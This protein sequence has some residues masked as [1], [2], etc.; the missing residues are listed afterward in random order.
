MHSPLLAAILL[1]SA[2]PQGQGTPTPPPTV[3]ETTV[4]PQARVADYRLPLLREGSAIARVTGDLTQDPDEKVWLFRPLEP[5]AGTIRR[6]FVL[7]PSPVLEDMLR[8]ERIAGAPVQFEMSGRVFIYHGRNFLL[9]DFA[10]VIMRFDAAT[11]ERPAASEA[12]QPAP[13][14]DDRFVPAEGDGANAE[15]REDAIVDEIERRLEERAGRAPQARPA[16][17]PSRTDASDDAASEAATVLANG[18]RLTRR[19]GR[20]S[21]DPQTGSWRFV[22]TQSTG[23]GDPSIEL[24]PCLLLERLE[25]A[26][27]ENDAAPAILLSGTV[28][29][30][31]G[32]TY[33]MPTSFRRARE[34]RGLGG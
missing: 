5:E 25:G 8:T 1:A 11:G 4:A 20:L 21:R 15:A 9:P 26:A 3:R 7:L 14:G 29:A 22:P 34:G 19:L 31:E 10:P 30:Y 16:S 18:T 27:R 24:L 33:L 12:T 32:R 23:R 2:A 6:E 13:S 28:Y 17:S